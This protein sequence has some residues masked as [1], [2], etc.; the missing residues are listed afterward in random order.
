[1]TPL[2]LTHTKSGVLLRLRYA[3][4]ITFHRVRDVAAVWAAVTA[5]LPPQPSASSGSSKQGRLWKSGRH[6]RKR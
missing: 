3:P 4:S 6:K 2:S 1:M 5:Q